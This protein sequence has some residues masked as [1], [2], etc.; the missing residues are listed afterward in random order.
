MSLQSPFQNRIKIYSDGA[1]KASMLEMAARPEIQGLTTNPSLMKK[2]GVSDYR[3]FCKEI[4][5]HIRTK[6]LSFEVFA[7]D[8]AEMKRQAL[9]IATW[10]PNVYVKIPITN[11]E[12]KTSIPLVHELAHKN[13]KLNVTAI[14]TFEQVV[15]T[16]QA[17][18]GGAPSI[19]SIFAGRIA[20]TGR[21]P[22]PLMTASSEYCR[23]VDKNI[24]LL[25]ASTREVFNIVQAEMAGCHIITSPPDL[26][27]KLNMINKDPKQMS[28]ETVRMFKADSEAAGFH[29]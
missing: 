28:L 8:F 24:E 23:S 26:V 10:G 12:G 17:V 29:L 22:M 6:P 21:D 13:V 19:V 9:E 11:S 20:D 15:E 4:L 27:K 18:K 14:F 16:V 7:D 1:D 25:W 2:A 3:A 5:T